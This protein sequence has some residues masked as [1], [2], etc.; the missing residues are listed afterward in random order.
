V[1][2]LGDRAPGFALP[3]YVTRPV[4]AGLDTPPRSARR[5]NL[6][7][8]AAL[9]ALAFLAYA[10]VSGWSEIASYPWHPNWGLLA[11]SGLVIL[12]SYF[13]T[14]AAYVAVVES[15]VEPRPERRRMLAIWGVSLLGRYVP[16]SVV[17]IGGRM[18]MARNRGV[19]RRATLAAM[20][21]EQVLAVGVAAG[22]GAAF[23][24]LY[25]HRG[26]AWLAWLVVVLPVGLVVLHPRLIGPALGRILR[27]VGREPLPQVIALERVV[28][29]AAWYLV[30]EVTLGVGAWIGVRA[31]GGPA[32]GSVVFITGAFLFAFAVSM[33]VVVV[34]SGLGLREG[35][36]AL[37]LAQHVPGSVAVALAVA[38]RV[39]I[40]VV[41]L[42]AVGIFALIARRQ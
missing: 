31:V 27:R 30:A 2:S 38:S 4:T 32:V 16:G 23:V 33:L 25:G 11:L 41:E 14:G 34:P 13:V 29:L 24:L 39:E 42:L 36:F 19:P 10:L 20:I 22:C 21:Y 40:T 15:L 9:L 28:V 5:R 12:L 6:G 8:A 1:A 18:E 37:A 35:A 7:I 3:P 17:M 26:P